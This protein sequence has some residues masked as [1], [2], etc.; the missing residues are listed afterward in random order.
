MGDSPYDR[1]R[2][3][4]MDHVGYRPDHYREYD[5]SRLGGTAA[6]ARPDVQIIK[7]PLAVFLFE[8]KAVIIEE[9]GTVTEYAR[10]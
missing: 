5:T 10:A 2:R 8:S 1:M 9:D 6:E 7:L 3:E 4:Q